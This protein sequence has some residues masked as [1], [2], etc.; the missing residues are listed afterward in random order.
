MKK[1]II[2]LEDADG[3]NTSLCGNKAAALTKLIKAR[4]T[5]PRGLCVSSKAYQAYIKKTW[6][7]EKILMELG[8]KRFK[9]MRWEEMWDAS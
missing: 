9:D 7:R 8:R 3:K 2:P 6:L 1:I 5:V 4:L